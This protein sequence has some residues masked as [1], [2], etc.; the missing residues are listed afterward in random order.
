MFNIAVY[1]S[2]SSLQDFKENTL[3]YI[4]SFILIIKFIPGDND[5]EGQ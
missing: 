5:I 1:Y 3:A 2:Y 4:V